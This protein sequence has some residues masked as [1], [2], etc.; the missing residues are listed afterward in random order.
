[1]EMVVSLI[2][3]VFKSP[4]LW[5]VFNNKCYLYSCVCWGILCM[6]W[7]LGSPK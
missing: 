7:T 2:N 4:T 6:E 1:M 5:P 3:N